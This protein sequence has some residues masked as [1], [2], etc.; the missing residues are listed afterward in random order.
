MGTID[1]RRAL[2]A[3]LI[4]HAPTFPP[5]SL[6][7]PEALAEDAHA[8]ASPHAFVLARLVWPA[9]SLAQLASSDRAVSAVLD[10]P[11]PEDARVESVETR[12]VVRDR[13]PSHVTEIY[14]ETPVDDGLEDRLDHLS[15]DGL[16]A[17]VRCGG[18]EV[19]GDAD[20]ARFV[21]SCR[22]RGLVFKATA[23]LH[24]AV[25]GDGEHGFLNLLAAVVFKGDEEDALAETEPE[26]FGLDAAAFSWRDRSASGEE[27]ARVR[28]GLFHS[29]G[30]CSFFE[31]VGELEALGMLPP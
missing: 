20:L 28:R 24:R 10:A 30:S 27:I 31:P 4:D 25:R 1:A 2:L 5:A 16:R 29:M 7:P 15:A 26:A 6:P 9:S 12:D 19:P 18:P 22:E 23:G 14:V 11:L 8:A 3:R 21:R 17:K 13:I